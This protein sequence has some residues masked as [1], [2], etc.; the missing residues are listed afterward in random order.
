VNLTHDPIPQ[1][2]RKIAIPASIGMF[3]STMY[4]IVDNFYAG[5]LSSTAVAGISL[6]SPIM[7]M[8]VAISIGIGQG[9]NALVGN[10]LGEKNQQH[11]EKIAGHALSFAWICAIVI[12][13]LLFSLIP[14]LF[15]L[16]SAHGDYTQDT[17]KYL[18]ITLPTL[19]FMSHAMAANGILNSLGDTTSFRN[20]L[21]VAFIANIILDPLF[22]FVFDWGVY[23]L[24]AAT[25]ATQLGSAIYLTYKVKQSALSHSLN[26]HNLKPSSAYYRSLI[27]QSLP[28]ST[29][30]FLIAIGSLIITS[31]VARFGEDAVAGLGIALRIEQL[32]LL[33]TIG[34]NIAVLSLV[35][36]NFGAK[37]YDRMQQATLDSIKIG[38]MLMV[39][40]GAILY[41]F[42]HPLVALFTHNEAVIA[43]GVSYLRIEAIIL[44]AYVLSF[45]AGAAL[46][47]MKRPIIPMYFNII[48]QIIL[49]FAFIAIALQLLDTGLLGV[50]ISIAI[51]T[52]FTASAQY[53]HM[54]H[55]IK[56]PLAANNQQAD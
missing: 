28:A 29:N 52:W 37:Q 45:V 24:A 17:I 41:L 43:I 7:F 34:I 5:M 12:A 51:A 20:S 40:G 6:A 39:G 56:S 55:Y 49:P 48:R 8:G 2:L 53:L 36:V 22:I 13:A 18:S 38:A 35:S 47:G 31:A 23:G 15:K 10:A 16:M 25:A 4:Y 44:P 30:M 46:Q 1:L 21:I 19:G 3:F 54:R 26:L 27:A 50:W 11:A 14:I 32:I 33:P 42:A 9:T